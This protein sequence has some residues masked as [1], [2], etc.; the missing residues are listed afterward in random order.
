VKCKQLLRSGNCVV[1]DDVRFPQE[2]LA[3]RALG[4]KVIRVCRPNG[5]STHAIEHASEGGLDHYTFDAVLINNALHEIPS[6]VS[7]MLKDWEHFDV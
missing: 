2:I 3:I 4:G 1:A 7:A 6:A 5:A